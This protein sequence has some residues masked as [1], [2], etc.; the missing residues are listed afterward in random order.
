MCPLFR[1]STVHGIFRI[2]EHN[3]QTKIEDEKRAEEG[4]ASVSYYRQGVPA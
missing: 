1:G 3:I 4:V 2:F